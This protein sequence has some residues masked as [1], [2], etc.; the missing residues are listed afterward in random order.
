MAPE[1]KDLEPE[2]T[3]FTTALMKY[4][5]REAT[6]ERI[7]WLEDQL[8]TRLVSLGAS[9]TSAATTIAVATG[10]SAVLRV[11]DML[12]NQVTGEAYRVTAIAADSAVTVTRAIGGVAAASSVSAAQLLI[13]G[14]AFEQGADVG[15]SKVM[16]RSNQYV[17][18]LLVPECG[19]LH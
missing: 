16:V 6:R 7:D 5:T 10:E 9:A 2:L 11:N 18:V 19:I 15:T 1:I 17:K 12:R 4:P 14:N 3:Q 13:I 8:Q